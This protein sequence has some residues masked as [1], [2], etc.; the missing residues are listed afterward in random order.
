[1]AVT[2]VTTAIFTLVTTVF[3]LVMAVVV[4][5]PDQA[6]ADSPQIAQ[7]WVHGSQVSASPVPQ[8]GAQEAVEVKV[9]TNSVLQSGFRANILMCSDPDAQP[10]NL[11]ISDSTCDGLTI[12]VGP[13]LN[14]GT[15]GTVDQKGYV[16]YKLPRK[17]EPADSIPVCNA[18]HACVL[19]VGQDQNDF[20]RPHVWSTAFYVGTGSQ[21]ASSSSGSS[22]P[23][24]VG[25]VLAA[26]VLA[27]GGFLWLRRR[28]HGRRSTADSEIALE[29]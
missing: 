10:K 16:I 8:L 17:I 9:P 1:V 7:I 5:M 20:Q 25:I 15:G 14:I 28:E 19:Y 26:L 12:Q 11:P 23:L 27:G 18:T 4:A 6:G 21:A 29:G 13:T 24:V 22:A 3:T 2:W